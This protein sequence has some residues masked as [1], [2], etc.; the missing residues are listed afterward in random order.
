MST[1]PFLQ[2]AAYSLKSRSV[3]I[4]LG[5]NLEGKE[6]SRVGQIQHALQLLI[7]GQTRLIQQAPLYETRPIGVNGQNS[8]INTV[9]HISTFLSP[10]GL[11]RKLKQL[12]WAEGRRGSAPR[13]SSRNLDMDIIDYKGLVKGW[14]NGVPER[15]SPG[16]LVL[17]HAH[18]HHRA[19][20]LQ[21]LLDIAPEWKHPVFKDNVKMLLYRLRNCQF[22]SGG[23]IIKII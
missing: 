13:W 2:R 8:Y 11:L 3:Y 14:K 19:F 10:Y 7:K 18:T 9:V 15:V 6:R 23:D 21:P 16:S 4:G 22:G 20:V 1:E 12:E 17:P 5:S